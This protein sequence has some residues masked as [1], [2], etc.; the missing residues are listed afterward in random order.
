M[1]DSLLPKSWQKGY[2]NYQENSN[3]QQYRDHYTSEHTKSCSLPKQT[4][5]TPTNMYKL[6]SMKNKQELFVTNG[7]FLC[8]SFTYNITF[9]IGN[10]LQRNR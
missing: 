9:N 1:I 8:P 4:I 6:I 2:K 5:K 10:N 7:I 3:G